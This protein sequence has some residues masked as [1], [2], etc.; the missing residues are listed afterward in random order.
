MENEGVCLRSGAR[1]LTARQR[2]RQLL[3]HGVDVKGRG[4]GRVG[5]G[6]DNGGRSS[7]RVAGP[8]R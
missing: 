2:A 1:A 3:A 5:D 6:E 8:W 4:G 7:A